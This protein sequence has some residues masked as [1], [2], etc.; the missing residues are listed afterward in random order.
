MNDKTVIKKRVSLEQLVSHVSPEE[1]AQAELAAKQVDTSDIPELDDKF[2][3]QAVRNLLY[4]PTKTST[5]LRV[6]SDVLA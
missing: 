6:D 3:Q 5:T 4:K 2:W 1:L